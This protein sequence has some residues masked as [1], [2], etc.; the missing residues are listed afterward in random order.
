MSNESNIGDLPAH[1]PLSLPSWAGWSVTM[2]MLR[3]KEMFSEFPLASE[4]ARQHVP[5]GYEVRIH[6]N[7]LSVLL[8]MVQDCQTCVLNGLIRISP[9][10]MSHLWIELAGPDEIGNALP[11][12]TASLP[13]QYYYA[14]PHQIDNAL[15]QTALSMV[16]I[17]VQRVKS[18]SLEGY[19]DGKRRGTVHEREDSGAHYHWEETSNRWLTPKVL[20]GRRWFYR[21]YGRRIRRRSEG[22]V[23]CSSSFLGEGQVRLDVEAESAI[24]RI[25]G[26]TTLYGRMNPV[27]MSQ[28]EARI[29]IGG[30]KNPP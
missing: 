6:Q 7:G 30:V 23:V 13:T 18:I 10:R 19:S 8:M 20:T 1:P 21:E 12:T 29:R 3:C 24:G 27:E 5:A 22:L 14:L 15:A 2:K 25:V 11:G 4:I 16:G 26:S 9:M 28:C 17:D